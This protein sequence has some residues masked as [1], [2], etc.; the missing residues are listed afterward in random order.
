MFP[1]AFCNRWLFFYGLLYHC[2]PSIALHEDEDDDEDEEE[3]DDD[4]WWWSWLWWS[5]YAYIIN[6]IDDLKKAFKLCE[7]FP[8]T[9]IDVIKHNLNECC[10]LHD[11]NVRNQEC[12]VEICEK[13][14]KMY[15]KL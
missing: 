8:A 7:K 10:R 15:L 3:Y 11:E 5:I 14:K 1:P 9:N 4:Q 13:M 6:D 2:S 12:V